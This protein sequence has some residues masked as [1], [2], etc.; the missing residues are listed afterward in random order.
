MKKVILYI[1]SYVGI[2]A[3]VATGY[4]MISPQKIISESVDSSEPSS[5]TPTPP[6]PPSKASLFIG[7]LM[8]AGNIGLDLQVTIGDDSSVYNV[9]FQGAVGYEDVDNIKLHGQM[10][11]DVKGAL[12]DTEISYFDSVLYLET[13]FMNAK[14]AVNTF[15]QGLDDLL[16][17]ME[18]TMPD[19][20][21]LLPN[22]DTDMLLNEILNLDFQIENGYQKADFHLTEDIVLTFYAN[23]DMKLEKVSGSFFIQGLK[24]D[25][26]ANTSLLGVGHYQ[27]VCPETSEKSFI[28]VEHFFPII[29]NFY[30]LTKQKQFDVDIQAELKK[31]DAVLGSLR[32]NAVFD[33][34]TR[35]IYGDFSFIKDLK[36]YEFTTAYYGDQLYFKLN[37]LFHGRLH[38]E[39]VLEIYDIIK[40]YTSNDIFEATSSTISELLDST[41][42]GDIQKGD[43]SRLSAFI[44]GIA[45]NDGHL[46]I[47]LDASCLGL[48]GEMLVIT[49]DNT[50]QKITSLTIDGLSYQEYDLSLKVSINDYSMLPIIDEA[51]YEDYAPLL[52]I[53]DELVAL[54]N[55]KQFA[56]NLDTTIMNQ[57]K[58]YSVDGLVQFSIASDDDL[59]DA[60]K[61]AYVSL[62]INDQVKTHTLVMELSNDDL[63]FVYNNKLKGRIAVTSVKEIFTMISDLIAE[64]D[65]LLSELASLM[66]S[67]TDFGIIGQII[68]KDYSGLSLDLIKEFSVQENYLAM[69]LSSS[70]CNAKD[71]FKLQINY[72]NN[73]LQS[74]AL[75]NFALDALALEGTLTIEAFDETLALDKDDNYFDLNSLKTLISLGITTMRQEYYHLVGSANIAISGSNLEIPVSVLIHNKN[76]QADVH[77]HLD[78]IPI[79]SLV[80][81]LPIG[82]KDST[83][84]YKMM[85]ASDSSSRKADIYLADDMVYINRSEEVTFKKIK[86]TGISSKKETYVRQVKTDMSGFT[87]N[88]TYYLFEFILGFGETITNQIASSMNMLPV[89]EMKFDSLIKDY[90]YDEAQH[91]FLFDID[92][93]ALTG[94]NKV[95]STLLTI[96]HNV[97]GEQ[98]L[99]GLSLAMSISKIVKVNINMEMVDYGMT[100]DMSQLLTFISDYP[101]EMNQEYISHSK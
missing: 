14:L 32:G 20:S 8:Q 44:K 53:Y 28:D 58:S 93:S 56:F 60:S 74:L 64:E 5:T 71:D 15:G 22:I 27:F 25:L 79:I 83:G 80:N 90:S 46:E 66:P 67:A 39:R 40:D 97:D 38:K 50:Q 43:Y 73:Q 24:V 94:D 84:E 68:N 23:D 13:N 10:N 91:Q 7:Q 78:N 12:I 88:L 16:T 26:N 11:F 63:Y 41:I 31:D 54:T 1:L 76:G 3:T 51:D 85:V 69:V 35:D 52:N 6:P 19:L 86:L 57:E 33:V 89:E 77:I 87:S 2:T 99:T 4:V 72:E 21:T 42:Y 92:F 82:L 96:T 17:K 98:Y 55:Q 100:L 49:L 18:I 61:S 37:N 95:D 65:P 45:L 101:Y 36:T 48:N 47:G 30:Q 59:V 34:S 62:N 75:E 9:D 81:S 70:V 29:D